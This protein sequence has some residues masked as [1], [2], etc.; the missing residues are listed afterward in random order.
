MA[1]RAEGGSGTGRRAL[2]AAVNARSHPA[3]TRGARIARRWPTE[4][5]DRSPPGDQR[6]DGQ[7]APDE[8]LPANRRHR[9]HAG[10]P[11]G[12]APRQVL[13]PTSTCGRD[14]GR[15]WVAP[16]KTITA[17]MAIAALGLPACGCRD[18][19]TSSSS[20]AASNTTAASGGGGY[21]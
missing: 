5:T 13:G 15:V 20:S 16:M 4:Q 9:P 10:R 12:A 7:G 14:R 18:A 1:A 8:H 21:G 3:R 6:E 11:L 17:L 2:G 19:S